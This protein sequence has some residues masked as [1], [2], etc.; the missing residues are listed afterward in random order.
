MEDGRVNTTIVVRPLASALPLGFFA[1]GIGMLLLAGDALGWSPPAEGKD[2]GMLLMA[3][4]FPLEF[5]AMSIAFQAA[6]A[7]EGDLSEQLSRLENEAGIRS[8]L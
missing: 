3:F 7:L 8:Q 1:F 2:V 5:A 6:R 4:V